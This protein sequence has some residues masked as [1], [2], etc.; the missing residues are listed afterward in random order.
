M[1]PKPGGNHISYSD[2]ARTPEGLERWNGYMRQ[3]TEIGLQRSEHFYPGTAREIIPED[4]KRQRFYAFFNNRAVIDAFCV[5]TIHSGQAEILWAG[6]R[7][8]HRK[9]MEELYDF[10]ERD[11]FKGEY[12]VSKIIGMTC[13]EDTLIANE[14]GDVIDGKK[15]STS[16]RF[17]ESRGYRFTHRLDDFWEEGSHAFVFM[18][19]REQYLAPREAHRYGYSKRDCYLFKPVPRKRLE[20]QNLDLNKRLYE[21]I[22]EYLDV[23]DETFARSFPPEEKKSFVAGKKMKGFTGLILADCVNRVATI[24]ATTS[25]KPDLHAE[26]VLKFEYD[27]DSSALT[28]MLLSDEVHDDVGILHY[29]AEWD[30]E[31]EIVVADY[32]ERIFP[33]LLEDGLYRERGF[34]VFYARMPGL[35][36]HTSVLY[37]LTADIENVVWY[38]PLWR[39]FARYSFALVLEIYSYF[40]SRLVLDASLREN[41]YFK[42]LIDAVSPA[43][44]SGSD[45]DFLSKI[46]RMKNAIQERIDAHYGAV[47]RSK[48]SAI[49]HYGHTLGHRLSPIQAYF[50]GNKDSLKRAVANAKFLGD[51]SVV[52]Q[53]INLASTDDLYRHPKKARFLEYE[54]EDGPL[55]IADRIQNEWPMLAESFQPV[56]GGETSQM[57]VMVL[58]EFTGSLQDAHLDFMLV[59][60]EKGEACR[61]REVFY[62]QLFSELL[63]NVVR[64]GGIPKNKIDLETKQASVRVALTVQALEHDSKKA[65]QHCPALMISN[66]IGDKAPPP[67]LSETRWTPWPTDRENDGPGMA[68]AILRRL[69][70]GELWY[71]YNPTKRVFRVAVWLKGLRIEEASRT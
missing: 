31:S 18:K 23:F 52:L 13:T 39:A 62:S 43:P 1:I 59:D 19:L 46:D 57:R 65:P 40:S 48:E 61:P 47:V 7:K 9:S 53:A 17:H 67:W 12:P 41:D 36:G 21:Q 27:I 56:G 51:L 66:K 34:T 22:W 45:D 11:L 55:N 37:F 8:G 14:D 42:S 29:E 2:L 24:F 44:T 15:W 5:A 71:R 35:N 30:T 70:L 58:I 4:A 26:T 28:Q 49:A 60:S 54:R 3:V 25:A 38:K 16:H 50:E 64:Y 33:S 6:C 32:C 20:D 68:I 63:L 69:G 10:L